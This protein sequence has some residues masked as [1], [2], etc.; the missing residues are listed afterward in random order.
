[1]A[2]DA[3]DRILDGDLDLT[4]E[5]GNPIDPD[6]GVMDDM[7]SAEDFQALQDK[8][9]AVEKE[10]HG[11]LKTVQ[12]ERQKRQGVQ[13]DLAELRGTV[14]TIL[15]T[16][17]QGASDLEPDVDLRAAVEY[18]DD[19]DGYVKLDEALNPVVDKLTQE[20]KELKDYISQ[21]E[22]TRE[23][24]AQ[25]NALI[26]SIVGEKPEYSSAYGRYQ[27]AHKWLDDRVTAWQNANGVQ[28]PLTGGE[29]LDYV[30][31]DD[32]EF[33]E[34]FP[35]MNI[36]DVL[37][38]EDSQYQLR[39]MLDNVSKGSTPEFKSPDSRF[40]KVLNK[41][42][43]LGDTANANAEVSVV[44]KAGNLGATDIMALSDEAAE[45]LEKAML[46][47]EKSEGIKFL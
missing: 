39:T 20:I 34:A 18:S 23:A 26:Q 3:L 31:Q 30:F 44:D 33:N 19:G 15:Q 7:P 11:M 14:N 21:S 36:A 45:Q 38:A 32:K 2:K 1:M 40:Q 17:K 22:Q 27:S 42:S 8:L 37:F 5:D 43:G 29:A 4:D 47:E 28:R 35:G 41:P 46:R 10:K 24:D 16:R 13:Q 9:D 25:G 12:S 6:E